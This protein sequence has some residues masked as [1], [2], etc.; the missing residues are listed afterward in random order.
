MMMFGEKE[1]SRRWASLTCENNR[2]DVHVFSPSSKGGGGYK[3]HSKAKE[4]LGSISDIFLYGSILLLFPR[5]Q[6]SRES[7]FRNVVAQPVAFQRY[8]IHSL[9]APCLIQ[10]IYP[11]TGLAI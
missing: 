4:I 7:S 3:Y 1:A 11:D 8:R 6:T 9:T 10:I 5:W 2:R